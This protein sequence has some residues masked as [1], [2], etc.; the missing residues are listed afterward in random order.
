[1]CKNILL[2]FV[3]SSLILAEN[4]TNSNSPAELYSLGLKY[5]NGDDVD[6]N[7]N[8]A[9]NLFKK[10]AKKNNTDA[11]A[12]L[13]E[14]YW[15]GIG[16]ENNVTEA[17]KW[18]EKAAEK[19]NI[20]A[21]FG[22]GYLYDHGI[23]IPTNNA[24]AFHWYMKAAELGDTDAQFNVGYAYHI[25]KGVETNFDKAFFWYKKAAEKGNADAEN[26]IGILYNQATNTVDALNWFLKAAMDE[27]DH[28]LGNIILIYEKPENKKLFNSLFLSSNTNYS[29]VFNNLGCYYLDNE[30]ADDNYG[31]ALFWF[32]VAAK[33]E[34]V[35]ALYNLGW[36][37]SHGIMKNDQ[38]AFEAYLKAAE[39]GD[40][41][42]QL[43][44]SRK[45]YK[46]I[47]VTQNYDKAFYWVK[48]AAEQ[49]LAD[50]ENLLGF[51]FSHGIGTKTN[52]A[53]AVKWYKKSAKQGY[54]IA[55][56][57]LGVIVQNGLGCEK[58]ITN[59][60][61]YYLNAAF[62]GNYNAQKKIGWIKNVSDVQINTKILTNLYYYLAEKN[63]A[64]A[65]YGIGYIY[66]FG[67]ILPKNNDKALD[68]LLKSAENGITNSFYKIAYIY[69]N[70]KNKKA[71]EWY[72]KAAEADSGLAYMQL[73]FA[74]TVGKLTKKNY[75]KAE[76]YFLK[77]LEYEDDLNDNFK[78]SI[79]LTLGSIKL[80]QKKR[81][82]GFKYLKK[83]RINPIINTLY[84]VAVIIGIGG[85]VIFFATIFTI[86]FFA[87][88]N[89][90][91]NKNYWSI[92]EAIAILALFLFL[93]IA[94]STLIVVTKGIDGNLLIF[95]YSAILSNIIVFICL[96][97]F[98][99]IRQASI[100]HLLGF[101]RVNFKKWFL[102]VLGCWIIVV[103]LTTLYS[104]ILK[105]FGIELEQQ[106][107]IL[108]IIKY[109]DVYSKISFLLIGGIIIPFFE[110][111]IFR[112]V[113]FQAL[114][115]KFSVMISIIVSALIFSLAHLDISYIIPIALMGALCAY[116]FE[117]TKSI[118]TPLGIHILNNVFSIS[119][120][121]FFL[122]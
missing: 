89:K 30:S 56:Y 5:F 76:Y 9:F 114:K 36:M 90:F 100:W 109:G 69:Q 83:A 92:P 39:K 6:V 42:A 68:F 67:T 97:I 11:Q 33:Q 47:G 37:Y 118:Y 35:K 96:L 32:N 79:Y 51:Y 106:K 40:M 86:M 15:R 111:I 25:G 75:E 43:N 122:K 81:T 38:A 62:D 55:K 80:Q 107:L 113:V 103:L 115:T 87:L 13:A 49:K 61:N 72:K 64:L 63:N 24:L 84:L 105:L 57:N 53:E 48:K 18:Y 88:K 94:S 110:E 19:N 7:D 71:I 59:A 14:C 116:S 85:G 46:G 73:G 99:K 74:Y 65:Q 52:F 58:N 119:A 70:K 101:Q 28:A 27:N 82:E 102:Y 41:D 95:F 4:I 60:F 50:A 117:K 10:A 12:K 22:L 104:L 54:T 93:Q 78:G 66:Y 108:E 17:I 121:L 29:K 16:T 1:M 91:T 8:L 26:N 21:L 20:E 120:A 44:V 45:F 77:A 34:N 23:G 3:F 112:G 2:I 31:K 98:S